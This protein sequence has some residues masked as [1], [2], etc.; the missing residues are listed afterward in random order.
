MKNPEQ[1]MGYIEPESKPKT[2][3]NVSLNSTNNDQTS[4]IK[5]SNVK[6]SNPPGG[7]SSFAFG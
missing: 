2:S 1:Q 3:N 7:K 5:K 4:N 6:I